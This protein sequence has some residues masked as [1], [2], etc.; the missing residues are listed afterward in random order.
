VGIKTLQALLFSISILL[1]YGD[2]NN[3][4]ITGIIRFTFRLTMAH[5]VVTI[6]LIAFGYTQ[7]SESYPGNIFEDAA[8][9]ICIANLHFGSDWNQCSY[10]KMYEM[11]E[12]MKDVNCINCDK[13]FH[14]QS[15][16]N[17]IYTN[18]PDASGSGRDTAI[19]IRYVL[20]ILIRLYVSKWA[21]TLER[22]I[23]KKILYFMN[24]EHQRG[25]SV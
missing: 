22:F 16:Y 9:A 19:K 11:Y 21:N 13:Y 5:M 20:F 24:G 1:L 25:R 4:N 15:N 18:C 3:R 17:A 2:N 14:C 12:K 7:I 23:V 8:T 6:L 10:D